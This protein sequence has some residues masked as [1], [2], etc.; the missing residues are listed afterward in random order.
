MAPEEIKK[1]LNMVREGNLSIDE[2]LNRLKDLPYEDLEFARIDHHRHVRQGM[3]EVIYCEGKRL[4]Q[5]IAIAGRILDKKGNLIATRASREIY[6]ALKT[7]DSRAEYNEE[8]RVIT[9]IHERMVLTEGIILI[10]T[11]GTAD[12]PVAEEAR[13]VLHALGS[14]VNTLYDV[15]VA[16]I[17]RLFANR[18]L[19]EMARVII[20][21]AGMDGALAS[22]VGG[23]VSV[24]VIAVPVSSGYGAGMGG[25]APLLTMLN[26][27][28]AGVA[29]LNIDNGFGA[30]CLAHKINMI[31]EKRLE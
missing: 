31:G 25:I 21:I 26:S 12:I 28:A 10:M 17:H 15:G 9:V 24:P 14:R 27:C 1:I 20:V 30:A 18:E 5:V 22:V 11:G 8:G 6:E 2:A 7:I 23:L 13:S 29:V 3:P 16:G 19:I 4:D